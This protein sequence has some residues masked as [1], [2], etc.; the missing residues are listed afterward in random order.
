MQRLTHR[1]DTLHTCHC[2]Q[3]LA[4]EA[5]Q[6][7]K[8]RSLRD[9]RSAVPMPPT[10]SGVMGA[11]DAALEAAHGPSPTRIPRAAPSGASSARPHYTSPSKIPRPVLA[12]DGP[13]GDSCCR[14]ASSRGVVLLPHW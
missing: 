6:A 14:S 2:V 9:S 4:A 10:Y 13:A 1:F 11:V 12:L 7:Q 8:E 3:T 5:A